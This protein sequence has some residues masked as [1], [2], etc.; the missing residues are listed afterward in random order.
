MSLPPSTKTR[1]HI[2]VDTEFNIAGAFSDPVRHRP[3]G[4]AAVYCTIGERS[5]GL[6]FL[7]DTLERHGQ[8]GTF[9]V[10]ALNTFHFGDAPMGEIAQRLHQGGHDVQLHIHPCWEYFSNAHWAAQLKTNPPN[11]DITRRS[12][13]EIVRLIEAGIAV[14]ARWGL[15]APTVLRTGGLRANLAVYR[16]MRRCGLMLASNLGL[17]VFRPSEPELQLFAGSHAIE[18]VTEIP[19]TT[20]SDLRIGGRTHLKTLTITGCAWAEIRAV[21]EQSRDAG[22]SDVVLLTHCFEYV[23]HRDV[24][25][26]KLYP[27]RINQR[28]LTRLCEFLAS[29]PGFEAATLGEDRVGMPGNGQNPL[30]NVPIAAAAGRMLVNRINHSI[31]RF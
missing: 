20:F 13:D 2:T 9:F 15:P 8:K 14:F 27:D 31:M 4:P 21:L 28:R 22:L 16:A 10:E 25:Y 26:E 7:L 18:G 11:D 3:V 24:T 23:K 12:E 6:G 29:E 19:V 17:A 30:F 1:V 5:H